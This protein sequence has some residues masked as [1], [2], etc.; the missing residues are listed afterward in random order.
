MQ[1]EAT[2]GDGGETEWKCH[3]PR[4]GRLQP[5]EAGRGRPPLEPL[6]GAQTW[7]SPDLRRLVSFR[8]NASVTG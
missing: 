2:R 7:D 1:Q 6:Q 3:Q 4:D 8:E 5:P